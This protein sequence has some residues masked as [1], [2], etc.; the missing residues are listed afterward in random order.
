MAY[1]SIHQVSESLEDL[2]KHKEL[3]RLPGSL[4]RYACLICPKQK[5]VRQTM[6]TSAILRHTTTRVHLAAR[7]GIRPNTLP[8][9]LRVASAIPSSS[10]RSAIQH[11]TSVQNTKDSLPV[12]FPTSFDFPARLFPSIREQDTPDDACDTAEMA[13]FD[14]LWTDTDERVVRLGSIRDSDDVLLSLANEA[15]P[16]KFRA[17]GHDDERCAFDDG[18]EI[19][20]TEASPGNVLFCCVR[21]EYD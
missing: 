6:I 13:P 15:N 5:G 10:R 1:Q 21:P 7:A 9:P 11:V 19:H 8:V 14:T 2:L 12:V 20:H 18:S 16:L 4:S 17:P 3:E